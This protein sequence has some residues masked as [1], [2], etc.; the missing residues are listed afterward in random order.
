ML[1]I[2]SKITD[3]IQFCFWK[4][5]VISITVADIFTSPYINGTQNAHE[6]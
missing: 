6:E 1:C 3:N 4:T 2:W 5:L